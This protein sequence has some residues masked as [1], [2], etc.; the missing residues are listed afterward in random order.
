VIWAGV[1]VGG[2]RKGFH[3]A[4]VDRAALVAGPVRLAGTDQAVDWLLERGPALVAVDAPRSPAPGSS[5]SRAEERAVARTICSL[6]YTPDAASLAGNP[7]YEWIVAG[8]ELYE[9][10]ER[11]RLRAVECFP[12]ASW[13][14][15]GGRRGGA[16]RAAWSGAALAATGLGRVPPTLG[17]DGRDAIG[18]ALTARAWSLGLA[19]RF[20]EIVVPVTLPR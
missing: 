14:R 19:E 1:D 20:G 12:T 10:L 6:R 4:A 9:A 17:Q 18:A 11:A 16:T 13:T 2:R 5:R 15:W 7:Y 8:F 3:L